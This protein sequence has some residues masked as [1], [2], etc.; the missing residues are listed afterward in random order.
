MSNIIVR[1]NE[2]RICKSNNLTNV[3]SLGEQYITSRFPNFNDFSTPKTSINL[4]LCND[5]GLLQ[6]EETTLSSELYEYEYGYR[7]GISN[8]MRQHLLDYQQE[9]L[10]KIVNLSTGDV[11]VD[12]GSND[13]TTLHYYSSDL[14]RIGIDPT[15]KQ[16]KQFYDDNIELLPRYFTAENYRE[17]YGDLKCKILSSISM[18]YDLPDPVQFAKDVYSILEDDGLWT[19]EQSYLLT[20]LERNS[21]DTICHEHLEYYALTQIKDIADRA[22]FKIID[23]KFNDCNGGSFRIYMAKKNSPQYEENSSLISEI[24]EREKHIKELSTYKDF[25]ERCYNEIQKLKDFIDIN[26]KVDKRM[27]IYGASTKGNCLLQYANINS[28]QISYAVERNLNK[29]GKM[30]STGIEIIDE[31]TMRKNP[32]KYL[33]VLPYHFK[34]EIIKRENDFLEG[35]GSLIFPLPHFEI[36][37]KKKRVI[38]TGSNGHIAHYFVE[39]YKD[40]YDLYGISHN[41][42]N[43]SDIPTFCIDL[44]NI[45]KLEYGLSIIKPDTIVHLA[46]I[47]SSETAFENPILTLE[48]NG[49]ITAHLCEMIHKNKWNMKLFNASSSEIYKGHIDY[50][51]QDNDTHFH[52]L[53]PYSIGKI[54]GH[55]MIQFYR[56][57]YQHCFFNGI[58]FTTESV[59]K[60][61]SF[62]LNKVSFHIKDWNNGLKEAL[63]VGNLD[64]YRNILHTI[65][66]ATAIETIITQNRGDDYL[67]CNNQSHQII[68]LVLKMYIK[69]NIHLYWNN[70]NLYEIESNLPVVIIEKREKG[71]DE[72]VT[73]I[74]GEPV[75]LQELGWNPTISIEEILDEKINA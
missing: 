29:V 58:I 16:F 3:I 69:S 61:R 60:N 74:K 1:L 19:L 39:L 20:M 63:Y 30:T 41:H 43:T 12:V 56:K 70:G 71:L 31:E 45:S 13:A 50:T 52:H 49:M 40:K 14:K 25:M 42:P 5:C 47:S 17:V 32:P 10:S 8:T 4:C 34:D 59:R 64:S 38:I 46:G 51:I 23:V 62:L 37:G 53:H 33:L 54:M 15:G 28:E 75:K 22:N 36:V 21:V 55:S 24:L 72:C 6:L 35:G 66:V 65:D 73:N 26:N 67:I 18:F 11:I 9:V 57:K 7:S 27:Y 48:T 68:S 44:L 2:C